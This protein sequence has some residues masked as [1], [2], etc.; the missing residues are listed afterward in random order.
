MD[1]PRQFKELKGFT[2]NTFNPNHPTIA[3][4]LQEHDKGQRLLDLW[5][6]K[7]KEIETKI[8]EAAQSFNSLFKGCKIEMPDDAL[9]I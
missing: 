8:K 9:G 3:K 2:K 4:L 5:T 6:K 1:D 7:G